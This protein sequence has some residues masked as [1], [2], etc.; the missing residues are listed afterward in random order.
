LF[1]GD[2]KAKYNSEA[3][4]M[5]LARQVLPSSVGYVPSVLACGVDK[6][7]DLPFLVIERIEGL[8]LRQALREGVVECEGVARELMRLVS[9]L[10]ETPVSHRC[11]E[12]F[13]TDCGLCFDGPNVG[14]CESTSEFVRQ[15]MRWSI[16]S[17][18]VDEEDDLKLLLQTCEEK[19]VATVAQHAARLVFRHGDLSIDNVM[20]LKE[21]NLL[22]LIDWE[23]AGIY[24]ERDVWLETRKY[25]HFCFVL[26]FCFCCFFFKKKGELLKALKMDSVWRDLVPVRFEELVQFDECK[27]V[28]MG[29]SWA[30]VAPNEEARQEEIEVL[31]ENL[32]AFIVQHKNS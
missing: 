8:S 12:S 18:R 26:C 15:M 16:R 9:L 32:E 22:C 19:V 31:R 1:W 23:F 5:R 2:S 20:L 11:V 4:A 14:P 27:D 13:G 29:M 24:D 10:C 3:L 28:F 6:E 21:S 7:T 25:I 17:C 30:A